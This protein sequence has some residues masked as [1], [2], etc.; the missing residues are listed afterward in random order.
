MNDVDLGTDRA[1]GARIYD[2]ILGGKDNY[3]VDR[4]AAEATKRI[5]PA[6]PVH[7]RANREF[8]HRAG[9]Y[10]AT[11]CGID[12]FLDIGTGIPTPPNL[13]EVVQE[14]RPDA[15][16]V[17]T[18]ND[19]IV[20]VHARAL[21]AGS[22]QG[23]TAYVEADLRDPDTILSSPEFRETLDPN[24]PIGLMLI[25]VVH[26]IEDDDEAL[27]VV[28]RIV[29]VLPSGSHLAAT[30]ATDDFAP[31]MLAEVRRTYHEHGETLRWRDLSQTERFFDGL[32]LVDPG[33]VQMHKWRPDDDTYR[34]IPEA[35]IAM[36][37]AIAR[38][39]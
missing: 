29:D 35:D 24:R 14:V 22:E 12:Q 31:E 1:H 18:D 6:L 4:A 7:M 36:Y 13:H 5:W 32:E 11:E 10:L 15:R 9:R 20:L 33:I 37:G 23:R 16:I 27:D 19:P 2:Y 39:P 28:R 3:A 17:Y 34:Q 8:M 25:A 38:K 21:M 30:V 26:F